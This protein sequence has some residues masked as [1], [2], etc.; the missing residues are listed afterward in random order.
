MKKNAIYIYKIYLHCEL[1]IGYKEKYIEETVDAD[2]SFVMLVTSFL[3][4]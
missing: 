1:S 2:F 4:E 3:K